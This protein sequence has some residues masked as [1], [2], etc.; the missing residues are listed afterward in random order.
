TLATGCHD[1]KV[2]L[3]D[4]QKN[5][6][7]K[8]ITAH[9]VAQPPTQFAVY[10][11]AWSADGKQVVSGSLDHTAKLWDV[12]SGNLVREVKAFKEKDFEKGHRDGVFCVAL[13]PDGKTLATGSSDRTIKLWNVADGTVIRELV[14]PK[15]KGA[16]PQSHPGWVYGVRFTADGKLVSAGGAPR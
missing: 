5:T 16:T 9:V 7:V 2:R 8:E 14:N 10:C 1:G 6:L 4:V 3:F 12:A 15:L 13:S 11:L